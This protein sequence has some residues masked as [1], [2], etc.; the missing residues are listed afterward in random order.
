MRK[1]QLGLEGFFQI[2]F[3]EA[4]EASARRLPWQ[5]AVSTDATPSSWAPT[6]ARLARGPSHGES[7]IYSNILNSMMLY[8][9]VHIIIILYIISYNITSYHHISSYHNIYLY[10]LICRHNV[11]NIGCIQQLLFLD[12]ILLAQVVFE[13]AAILDEVF[14]G[15]VTVPDIT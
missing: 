11:L 9:Y 12:P 7:K 14:H 4:M 10:D 15:N 1:H 6:L 3:G 13:L 8:V 5:P 2:C